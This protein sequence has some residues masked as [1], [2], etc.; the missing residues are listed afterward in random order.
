MKQTAR[1]NLTDLQ[2][3]LN[4]EHEKVWNDGRLVCAIS[5]PTKKKN[6]QKQLRPYKTKP[7][8]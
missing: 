4:E 5:L 2:S 1:R 7:G 6:K 8:K 3:F